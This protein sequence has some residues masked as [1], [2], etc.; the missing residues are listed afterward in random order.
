[1]FHSL[2]TAPGERGGDAVSAAAAQTPKGGQSDSAPTGATQGLP[3]AAKPGDAGKGLVA[4]AQ[5][6]RVQLAFVGDVMFAGN[7]EELLKK[8]GFDYPFKYV[9]PLLEKADYAIANLETPITTRGEAQSKE[10]TYRSPPEALSELKRA[11]VDLVNLA[12]NHSMDYGEDG[13]LDTLDYLDQQALVRVGA[14][15]NAEEAYRHAI[16]EKNGVK[17]A[18]LGFSRVLPETSWIAGKTKPGLAETYSTK[19]PLE[20][21]R[22]ARAEA[23]LV[24]VL[25]HWGEERKDIP[26]AVQTSLAHQFIDEGA[27][28]VVASHPHVLQG[29][30]QYKGKWI[31]YSLGNFIFTT[32]DTP[33]TWESMILQ[34]SCTKTRACDLTVVP[35][36][37]KWAQPVRMPDEDG[38][39]LLDKLTK[40]SANALIDKDGKL[41]L[42]PERP[43]VSLL[44]KSAGETDK[45]TAEDDKKK[46]GSTGTGTGTGKTQGTDAAK[47]SSPGTK[48]S[49]ASKGTTN[50]KDTSPA[51]DTSGKPAS[52]A[53]AGKD[54][55]TKQGSGKDT[56]SKPTSTSTKE[57]STKETTNKETSTKEKTGSTSGQ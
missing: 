17:I 43:F 39:S 9:K 51:K 57:T 56:T 23:D 42:G 12:N 10:Y 55:T 15:R 34:A 48:E 19:L 38:A 5:E 27:D 52:G 16:V 54:N 13:L 50:G 26:N 31:A 11:G 20:A 14:G 3:E 6:S 7:V 25:A 46:S 32:N 2:D 44:P 21:I 18:F 24:V 37:S 28:L 8:N 29:F 1:M 53:G 40:L 45:K 4:S 33:D 35:V 36:I 41:S 49:G 47:G 30:E 22:K